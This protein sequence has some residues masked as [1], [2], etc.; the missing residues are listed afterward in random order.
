MKN[1]ISLIYKFLI[2]VISGIGLYLN[3]I[4]A[5]GKVMIFYFTIISNVMVFLFYLISFILYLMKKLKKNR[6]YYIFKGM[7]TMCITLTL[8]VYQIILSDKGMY[9]GHMLACNFVHL[10]TP[11]LVIFDYIIFGKKGNLKKEFPIIWSMSLIIYTIICQL[12]SLFG[13]TF[14][15]G[16]SYPYFYMDVEKFGI[17]GVLFN[18]LIIYVIFL[19]YG[20]LICFLDNQVSKIESKQK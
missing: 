2:I 7:V 4:I 12:Y 10:Y 5:P 14:M 11:L 9:E 19:L 18:C 13:G 8:G 16:K 6:I 1:K 20:Y 3:A 15:D 17:I